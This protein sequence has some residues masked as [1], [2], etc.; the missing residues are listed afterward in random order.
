VLLYC[1]NA[2]FHKAA[3]RASKVSATSERLPQKPARFL[4]RRN[5]LV[6]DS[7]WMMGVM[8]SLLHRFSD[9]YLV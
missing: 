5:C 4:R 8:V 1:L 7:T 6:T 9:R 3:A 2:R